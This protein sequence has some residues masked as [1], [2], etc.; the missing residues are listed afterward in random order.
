MTFTTLFNPA[1]RFGGNIRL[2]TSNTPA[3][4]TW[5]VYNLAHALECETPGGEWF[6]VV[7]AH[8]PNMA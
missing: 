7:Q 8:T 3:A 5:T 4:G 1:I 2:E 6:T